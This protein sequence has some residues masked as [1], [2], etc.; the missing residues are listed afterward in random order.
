MAKN[1]EISSMLIKGINDN[2]IE[3]IHNILKKVLQCKIEIFADTNTEKRHI[4]TIKPY[5]IELYY[6]NDQINCGLNGENKPFCDSDPNKNFNNRLYFRH[7]PYTPSGKDYRDRMDICLGNS[8]ISI[9]VLIKRADIENPNRELLESKW[10]NSK[11]WTDSKISAI[12]KKYYINNDANYKRKN[13]SCTNPN[14][15]LSKHYD[16]NNIDDL[17]YELVFS[18]HVECNNIKFCK[19]KNIDNDNEYACYDSSKYRPVEGNGMV[20][21]IK[22]VNDNK[23]TTKILRLNQQR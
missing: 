13:K 19:R 23:G 5:W 18:S 10:T 17:T 1:D 3:E 4:L 14:N 9:S 7:K 6:K 21:E 11:E 2:N 12:A 15:E 16:F 20:K 8:D 22:E